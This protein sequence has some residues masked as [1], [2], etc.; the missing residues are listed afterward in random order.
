MST[1]YILFNKVNDQ[2]EELPT[3]LFQESSLM[4]LLQVESFNVMRVAQTSCMRFNF[5]EKVSF[6][7]KNIF[8]TSFVL[9]NQCVF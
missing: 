9:L 4:F 2:Q 7:R 6:V 3:I 5:Q 1:N 8:G